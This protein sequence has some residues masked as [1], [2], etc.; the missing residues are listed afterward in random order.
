MTAT[1]EV[2]PLSVELVV[3]APTVHARVELVVP[4]I[5][6]P[7]LPPLATP[8]AVDVIVP[9]LNLIPTPC[10]RPGSCNPEAGVQRRN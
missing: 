5:W 4:G 10:G 2:R 9:E 3:P 6:P 8:T 1:P 7:Q